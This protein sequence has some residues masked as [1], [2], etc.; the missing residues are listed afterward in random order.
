MPVDK[1]H[2]IVSFGQ[3]KCFENYK[4]LN[5]QKRKQALS[6]FEKNFYKLLNNALCQKILKDVEN[7]VKKRSYQKR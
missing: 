6:D 7:R 2:E 5:D 3:S 4:K 1:D